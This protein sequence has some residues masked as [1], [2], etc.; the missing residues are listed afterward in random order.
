MTGLATAQRAGCAVMVGC[1]FRWAWPQADVDGLVEGASGPCWGVESMRW[2]LAAA[3][4]WSK[5]GQQ[6]S[7][8]GYGV[9]ELGVGRFDGDEGL[10]GQLRAAAGDAQPFGPGVGGVGLAA[11]QAFGFQLAQHL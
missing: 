9:E 2:W 4:E 1:Q 5:H 6:G 10:H 7:G 11:D 3:G 8:V